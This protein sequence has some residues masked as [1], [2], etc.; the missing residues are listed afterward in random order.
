MASNHNLVGSYFC[1]KTRQARLM[2]IR[3]KHLGTLIELQF[4]PTNTN[5]ISS[6]EKVMKLYEMMIN[7]EKNA[8]IFYRSN[9]LNQSLRKC[10]E[11]SQENLCVD[12]GAEGVKQRRIF[13]K[14]HI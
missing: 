5:S 1:N 13:L 11:T 9:S 10:L 4:S 8:L 2:I 14:V 7:K 12:I 6:S 3:L